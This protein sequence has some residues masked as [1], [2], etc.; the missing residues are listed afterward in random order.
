MV[1]GGCASRALPQMGK[2][3]QFQRDFAAHLVWRNRLFDGLLHARRASCGPTVL[4]HAA[5]TAEQFGQR[6]SVAYRLA[7][8]MAQKTRLLFCVRGQFQADRQAKLAWAIVMTIGAGLG[9]GARSAVAAFRSTKVRWSTLRPGKQWPWF[10]SA[11]RP[12]HFAP[13]YRFQ[14]RLAL[15]V[16]SRPD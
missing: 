15:F 3:T 10:E 7:V 16:N 13:G 5:C 12:G 14:L 11:T 2:R 1:D 9:F 4:L 8:L 6:R